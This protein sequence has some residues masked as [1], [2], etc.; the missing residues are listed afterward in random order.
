M[1]FTMETLTAGHLVPVG[2]FPVKG[3][4]IFS[5]AAGTALPYQKQAGGAT[6]PLKQDS[7]W[8]KAAFISTFEKTLSLAT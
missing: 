1:I 7:G 4:I 3:A 5:Q 6:M 8:L 2:R